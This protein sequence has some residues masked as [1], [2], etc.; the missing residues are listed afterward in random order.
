MLFP[1]LNNIT[2]KKYDICSSLLQ[3]STEKQWKKNFTYINSF[4]V[5]LR[6]KFL[7][8]YKALQAIGIGIYLYI[9]IYMYYVEVSATPLEAFHAWERRAW[10]SVPVASDLDWT[11][12]SNDRPM[13][14]RLIGAH[15]NSKHGT[16]SRR[17]IPWFREGPFIVFIVPRQR[18]LY[19]YMFFTR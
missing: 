18:V 3:L 2:S 5:P 13:A 1:Y 8:D 17:R 7:R 9:Y 10:L 16:C 14:A 4:M 12:R 15:S 19:I 11:S 6:P